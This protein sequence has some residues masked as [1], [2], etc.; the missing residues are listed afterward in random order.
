V[1]AEW[2]CTVLDSA[3]GI[4]VCTRHFVAFTVG[5]GESFICRLYTAL[6]T[7]FVGEGFATVVVARKGSPTPSVTALPLMSFFFTPDIHGAHP[8]YRNKF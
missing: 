4:L 8:D 6:I 2:A 3:F 7:T 1:W 5:E